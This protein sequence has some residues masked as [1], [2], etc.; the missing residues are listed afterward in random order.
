MLN[1]HR[2]QA[3]YIVYIYHYIFYIA[4]QHYLH[5]IQLDKQLYILQDDQRILFY[6]YYIKL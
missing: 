3:Q 1:N 5:I 2:Y 6:M 4:N